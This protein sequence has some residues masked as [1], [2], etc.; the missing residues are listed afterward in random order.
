MGSED[1][2]R[3]LAAVPGAMIFLGACPPGLDYRAAPYNHAPAARFD[4]DVLG[5][6]ARLYAE[7]ALRRLT[8]G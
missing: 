7:L 8:R 6:G 5:D 4:D 3:I 1:F 2:S